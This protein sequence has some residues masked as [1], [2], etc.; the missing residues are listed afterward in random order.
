[1]QTRYTDKTGCHCFHIKMTE[2]KR[3]PGETD[4]AHPEIF[5]TIPPQPKV[6]KPGQL[7]EEKIKQFFEQGFLVVEKFFQP[8]ELNPAIDA[9]NTLV[10]ELAQ[11]LYKAGKTTSLYSEYGFYERL[12]KLEKE[13]PGSNILLHKLGKLPQA[14][15][16]IWGSERLLN[17]AEQLLGTADLAGH[18]VWN[19]RTKTPQ[20]E[21]A[22]VPWH[23]DVA[24]L[25][26]DSYKVF[27]LTSWIPLLDANATNGCMQVVRS[28]H[29]T[30][31]V[32]KHV[33][34]WRDT[35]YVSLVEEDAE[36]K[37]GITF[38]EDTVTCPIPF[39]GLLLLNNIVPHRSLDNFSDKI[40]WSLDLRWQ[41]AN[42]MVGF[43]G[44]KDG[45]RMRSST[46]PNFKIDWEQ[47]DAVSRHEKQFESM[48]TVEEEFDT[49]I[50]GPWMKKWELVHHNRHTRALEKQ[51]GETWHNL[52]VG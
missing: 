41:D 46:D 2:Q 17:L 13:F 31:K 22:T 1:M 28:G 20:S 5:N 49:T 52:I 29:K 18:P 50:P 3:W 14:F 32:A 23:Q 39:G 30:G 19:L 9:V 47:F 12:T 4:E 33:G 37:L 44:L 40:R 34:C 24:Y 16:D 25:D 6:L 7:P 15:R 21:A 8:E 11:K 38:K 48:N 26:N 27:Q 43:F 51:N 45:V 10:E 42:K 36:K 35:W